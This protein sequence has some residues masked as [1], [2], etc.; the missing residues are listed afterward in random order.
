MSRFRGL[1]ALVPLVLLCGCRGFTFGVE[2]G[3]PDYEPL[4]PPPPHEPAPGGY[5][6]PPTPANPYSHLPQR[7][8]FSPK[9]SVQLKEGCYEGDFVL[10]RSQIEVTGAGIDKTVIHGNLVLQ[11]QC[12]VSNLTVSGDVIFEGHQAKFVD[13][14]F[15]GRIIDKGSQNTY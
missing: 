8:S 12:E 1:L 3:F 6:P 2:A 9:S 15:Y 5:P 7:M 4:P 14:D 13:A 10:G 11:T